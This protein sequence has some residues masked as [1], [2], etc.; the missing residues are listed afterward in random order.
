MKNDNNIL[1]IGAGG[2]AKSCI[3]II[4]KENKH[5]I[6]GL[7]G[8]SSELGKKVLGYKVIGDESLL[9]KC[10]LDCQSAVIG[11]GQIKSNENRKYYYNLLKKIG[12][13]LP[14]I[15]SPNSVISDNSTVGESSIIM[16][17]VVINAGSSIGANC[18]INSKSLIEHD[19]I[20][21]DNCHISTGV[22]LNGSA[23]VGESSFVGS[24]VIVNQNITI[25]NDSV[26]RSGS[27]IYKNQ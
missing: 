24:G 9:E 5:K 20:I 7:I 16:H 23:V 1:I 18:I 13:S 6:I 14:T 8:L 27:I 22:I 11:I 25:E 21:R 26:I 3:E 10:F 12:Y 15:I 19:V 2:H 17:N 4:E